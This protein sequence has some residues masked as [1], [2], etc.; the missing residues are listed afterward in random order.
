MK[1][2]KNYKN[3]VKKYPIYSCDNCP[4]GMKYSM[5]YDDILSGGFGKPSDKGWKGP[6]GQGVHTCPNCLETANKL[7]ATKTQEN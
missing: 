6:K 4:K 1:T 2:L 3:S 5:A 7:S